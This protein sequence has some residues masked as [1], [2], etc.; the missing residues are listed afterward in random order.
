MKYNVVITKKPGRLGNRLFMFAHLIA[1]SL[2]FGYRVWNPTF[3]E[4]CEYFEKLQAQ[5]LPRFP[6]RKDEGFRLGLLLGRRFR[7]NLRKWIYRGVRGVT[8]RLRAISLYG[9][10]LH[11]LVEAPISNPID[12]SEHWWS[13]IVDSRRVVL[14]LGYFVHDVKALRKH[15]DAI[16]DYFRPRADLLSNAEIFIRAKRERYDILI[17]LHVRLE[18]YRKW[19][20]GRYY[21]KLDEYAKVTRSIASLFPETRVCFVVCS[22]ET[23]PLE[24]FHDVHTERGPGSLVD[25]LLSLSL[26]DFIVGPPSSFSRWAAFYGGRPIL[27]LERTD[28]PIQYD[29]FRCV[30]ELPWL[31]HSTDIS[32][33]VRVDV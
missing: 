19:R 28:V 1:N 9:S 12:L 32:D 16:R 20:G 24:V 5:L 11:I 27:S 6:L 17:G 7:S 13:R 22:G 15:Q 25:D 4:Y 23:I 2:E 14:E 26:C 8:K 18:D 3:L 33:V 29:D 30:F 21:Y 10:P 31:N